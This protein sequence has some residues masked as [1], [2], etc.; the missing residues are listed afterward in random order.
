MK[1]IHVDHVAGSLGTYMKVNPTV[2]IYEMHAKYHIPLENRVY[3]FN[4]EE[5]NTIGPSFKLRTEMT[6]EFGMKSLSP[7]E[8]SRLSER[9]LTD[10][11]L[12]Q[13]YHK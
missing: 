11:D 5:A 10:N 4:I 2:R 8:F 13:R 12:A 1:P 7:S 6:K 9:F 3:E